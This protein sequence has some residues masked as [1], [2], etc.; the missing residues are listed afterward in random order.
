M[1]VTVSEVIVPWLDVDEPDTNVKGR[2][3]LGGFKFESVSV[4]FSSVVC[5]MHAS[6]TFGKFTQTLSHKPFIGF[7]LMFPGHLS[8]V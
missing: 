8:A 2:V 4:T 5:V 3:G 6:N 1:G 7:P